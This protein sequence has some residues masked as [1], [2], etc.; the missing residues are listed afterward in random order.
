MNKTNNK[1]GVITVNGKEYEVN[2][3]VNYFI[4]Y[5]NE[6]TGKDWVVDMADILSAIGKPA[7][8]NTIA[9]LYA[10]H[11]AQCSIDK[12]PCELTIEQA[13]EMIWSLES[14]VTDKIY[15]ECVALAIG[16]TVKQL[17]KLIEEAKKNLKAQ[18]VK[19]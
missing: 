18:A 8:E 4:K 13:E 14:K 6:V 5:F 12:K 1:Q 7:I 9:F 15:N 10:G 16:I 17:D 2:F 3:G 19:K 11:K